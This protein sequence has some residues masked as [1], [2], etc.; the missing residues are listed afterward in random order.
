MIFWNKK[1]VIKIRVLHRHMR[2]SKINELLRYHITGVHLVIYGVA[3]ALS[4]SKISLEG[5][6]LHLNDGGSDASP[7]T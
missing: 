6:N 3:P 2:T 4:D 5:V 7:R 1:R